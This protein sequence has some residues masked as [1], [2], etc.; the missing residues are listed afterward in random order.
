[1]SLQ[2][3]QTTITPFEVAALHNLIARAD[4]G[5]DQ[6]IAYKWLTHARSGLF[7]EWIALP[8]G[9]HL[10]EAYRD[11]VWTWNDE[12]IASIPDQNR[13]SPNE[14]RSI[15]DELEVVDE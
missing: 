5:Q 1:M 11:E 15:V 14:V 6:A 8:D 7:A 13:V 2:Y 12:D 9:H 3:H 4:E 10:K